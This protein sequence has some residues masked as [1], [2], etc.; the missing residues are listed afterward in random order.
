LLGRGDESEQLLDPPDP[1]PLVPEE[2]RA[3]V[4]ISTFNLAQGTTDSVRMISSYS[5]SFGLMLT[6]PWL[7]LL[8]I[9]AQDSRGYAKLV[10]LC[11]GTKP[12]FR[13]TVWNRRLGK[14]GV[15]RTVVFKNAEENTALS[16]RDAAD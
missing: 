8:S 11:R 15:I 6:N 13:I 14:E 7:H 10:T 4:L 2:K 12:A 16:W 1:Q 5:F 9:R 3:I